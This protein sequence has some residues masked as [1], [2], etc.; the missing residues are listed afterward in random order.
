MR[1]SVLVPCVIAQSEAAIFTQSS[2]STNKD[3]IVWEIIDYKCGSVLTR[4]GKQT[5]VLAINTPACPHRLHRWSELEYWDG[6]V[7]L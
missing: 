6:G 4:Y 1:Q 3:M 7:R 5:K 2:R